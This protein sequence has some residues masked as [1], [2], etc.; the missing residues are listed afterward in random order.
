VDYY[1][2]RHRT[3]TPSENPARASACSIKLHSL[4]LSARRRSSYR[5]SRFSIPPVLGSRSNH[6]SRGNLS[7]HFLDRLRAWEHVRNFLVKRTPRPQPFIVLRK[8]PK[9]TCNPQFA[10]HLHP[11]HTPQTDV[12]LAAILDTPP[13]SC[14]QRGTPM[15][16]SAMST[17]PPRELKMS[18]QT[19]S[20]KRT[21]RGLRGSAVNSERIG[22]STCRSTGYAI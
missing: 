13:L 6:Q 19:H 5:S 4:T 3:D 10:N 18:K 14:G 22:L 16:T 9:Q 1:R 11:N 15:S 21:L 7:C 17:P 20:Q 2:G 8:I 12:H